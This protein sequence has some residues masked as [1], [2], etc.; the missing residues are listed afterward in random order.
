LYEAIVRTAIHAVKAE[1]V[2]TFL[3]RR[4]TASFKAELGNDFNTRIQ[5]TRIRHHMGPATIKMYDKFARI[6]RIETTTNKVSFFRHTL[7]G[8]T[9]G[10]LEGIQ[11][12]SPQEDHLQPQ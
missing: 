6:L 7:D 3:G 11:A 8:G 5:G 4:L 2:A 12:R 10:R 1:Q 9:S